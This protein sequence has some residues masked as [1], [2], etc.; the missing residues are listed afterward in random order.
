MTTLP[1]P[2]TYLPLAQSPLLTGRTYRA[3]AELAIRLAHQA[4]P[5]PATIRS[6]LNVRA[7][8]AADQITTALEARTDL[9]PA[10]LALLVAHR[11]ASRPAT[12]RLKNLLFP[13]PAA[14][15]HTF[16]RTMAQ[17]AHR[18]ET[19]DHRFLASPR[20]AE[21]AA[22]VNPQ[23]LNDLLAPLLAAPVLTGPADAALG[24]LI[25][26]R[27]AAQIPE[28][29]LDQ[30]AARARERTRRTRIGTELAARREE[31]IA[32]LAQHTG[33]L[34]LAAA[35]WFEALAEAADTPQ[36]AG[37]A[38][39]VALLAP[40]TLA[41][42]AVPDCPW[43]GVQ[44]RWQQLRAAARAASRQ[45]QVWSPAWQKAATTT[46]GSTWDPSQRALIAGYDLLVEHVRTHYTEDPAPTPE[47][48][49]ASDPA[50]RAL[51]HTIADHL[52]GHLGHSPLPHFDDALLITF[53]Q[54]HAKN[55]RHKIPGA[56]HIHGL[57]AALK[58]ARS[59]A[60]LLT[61]TQTPDVGIVIPMRSETGRLAPA[62]PDN[63]D[64]LDALAAKTAQLAWLLET[65]PDA[66]AHLLLIDEAPDSASAQA[67]A[68][69][70]GSHPRISITIAHRADVTSSKGGAVLWGL[71]Q[72]HA[73]GHTTLAYTDL[74]LTY[75]L[76]QLGLHL[77]ALTRSGAGAVI[78]SRRRPDS[79]GY[80]PPA[81]PTPATL[82]YTQVVN[83][84]L[85][86]NV[87]DPQAGFKAFTRTALAAALPQVT[88][89]RLSF[90]TDLLGALQHTG[91]HIIE[92][93]IAALHRYVNGQVGTPRDYD[94]M[95]AA[96][97]QQ[98]V[99]HGLD[100]SNRATPIWDRI[101][102]AGSLTDAAAPKPLSVSITPP[103]H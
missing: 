71:N 47:R 36:N 80:Y 66:R 22:T 44:A 103:A 82:L 89:H 43:P 74:D 11:P 72:L 61:L 70:T 19:I 97:H 54:A 85:S 84:L 98:A 57:I 38:L 42:D 92:V 1:A 2:R 77:E 48:C 41:A 63:P 30:A 78:G 14:G 24:A 73:A 6:L 16:A 4:L 8:E 9:P 49:W 64:G 3:D 39:A 88:D 83:E 45:P 50:G 53:V 35:L 27:S 56:L 12:A 21:A 60:A 102:G 99:R 20:F 17:L 65:R 34:T 26:A 31:T 5:D 51:L 68:E 62:S 69:L 55:S 52:T 76:D 32:A 28:S 81:G 29:D 87:S 40:D 94:T 95:L 37:R 7:P 13:G 75:P 91:N 79:H 58:A 10:A 93:G 25:Q 46:D 101:R 59:K 33:G 90:D 23:A 86:L 100:P 67:A 18:P 96:V 15:C